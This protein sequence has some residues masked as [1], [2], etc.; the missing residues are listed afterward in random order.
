MFERM[1]QLL[2]ASQFINQLRVARLIIEAF[3]IQGKE[4]AL[5]H[6]QRHIASPPCLL[7]SGF[8]FVPYLTFYNN[9]IIFFCEYGDSRSTYNEKYCFCNILAL[10]VH[11]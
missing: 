5:H 8:S 7:T 9:V 3:G 6:R 4:A 10:L 2:R 11:S 1:K